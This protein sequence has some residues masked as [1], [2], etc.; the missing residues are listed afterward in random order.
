MQ[1]NE[2]S[3]ELAAIMR[4][5]AAESV[6]FWEKD[7]DGWADCW[8]HSSRARIMGWWAR[9]GVTV[10]EGWD[11]VSSQMK[12]LMAA[13]PESN[14]TAAQVRRE[15]VNCSIG[16]DMA[17]LTFDQYGADTGDVAMDMPGLS[18]ETRILE[19]QDGVWKIVYVCWLL[20][21]GAASNQ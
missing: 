21:D 6:A 19:K 18:R 16:Q 9:G 12:G 8:V 5:I 13:N 17:W 10:V 15:N 4:V 14:P 2:Q 11:A 1:Q 20:V 3:S 7:F